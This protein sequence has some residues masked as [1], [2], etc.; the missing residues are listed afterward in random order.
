MGR[1]LAFCFKKHHP[2]IQQYFYTPSGVSAKK[3]AIDVNGN[4]VENILE[5]PKILDWYILGFKPQSL[6]DF[7]FNFSAEDKIVSILAGV[8]TGSLEKKFATKNLVRIM[9]NLPSQ[10]GEGANL[11]FSKMDEGK[12]TILKKY[13]NSLGSLFV[14]KSEN[15]LDN[16]TPFSG[17][18]PALIFELIKI[19]E[20]HLLKINGPFDQSAELLSQV[21]LGSA[22]FLTLELQKGTSFEELRN[23]VTSKKGITL[24]AL[25]SLEKNNLDY[26]I[27]E[28]FREAHRRTLEIKKECN[29]DY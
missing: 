1:A 17:S 19:F 27:G 29:N 8:D 22:K 14:V 7:Q 13:L 26:I 9:P 5:M 20:K 18:S 11:F 3:L 16:L 6:R 25:Q 28:A 23:R 4:F 21:F 24:E 12:L 2:D 15:E 10:I